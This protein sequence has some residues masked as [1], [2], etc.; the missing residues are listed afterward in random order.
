MYKRQVKN[1]L[2]VDDPYVAFA[3]A[4]QFFHQPEK[5]VCGVHK[6]AVVD[7]SAIVAASASIGAQCVIGAGAV[8]ENDVI[9]EAGTVI[10]NGT[11]IGENTH[12]AANVTIARDVKIGKNCFIQSGTVIGS[13][14]FGFANDEGAW[15]KIPQTGSVILGNNVEVGANTTIDRGALG[16]TVIEDGVIMDNLVQV[17]HNVKIGKH[18]AIAGGTAIAGSTTIGSGCTVGGLAGIIGHLTITD[19]VHISSMTEVTKSIHKPGHFTG[20]VPAMQHADWTKNMVR[21]RQLEKLNER[22]KFLEE[23][24]K[25]LN[26]ES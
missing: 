14:G 18:T 13:D 16:D 4:A 8:I 22:V 3:R 7:E 23:K 1:L 15:L 24:I 11:V 5:P 19:N 6:T 2:I 26:M 10:G 21:L 17:A 9:I 12:L 20:N 25:Q